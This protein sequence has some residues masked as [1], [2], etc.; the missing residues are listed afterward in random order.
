MD[1]DRWYCYGIVRWTLIDGWILIDGIVRWILI[2]GIVRWILIDGIVRWI[3]ID[4]IVR[5]ILIDGIVRWILK[6][7]IVNNGHLFFVLS[8]FSSFLNH[9]W[10]H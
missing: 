1:I 4:G 7:G 5:W 10:K 9:V 3:L 6:N 8:Y 2:D